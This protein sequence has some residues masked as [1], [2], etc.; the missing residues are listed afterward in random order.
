MS[1]SWKSQILLITS[2]IIKSAMLTTQIAYHYRILARP[3]QG[4]KGVEIVFLKKYASVVYIMPFNSSFKKQCKIR[5]HVNNNKLSRENHLSCQ[6]KLG[7]GWTSC[8]WAAAVFSMT[9]RGSQGPWKEWQRTPKVPPLNGRGMR[10]SSNQKITQHWRSS[11]IG[12]AECMA[13]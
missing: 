7:E 6:E 5:V 3:H 12:D 2:D 13:K 1:I 4:R 11:M 9:P 8:R 10:N